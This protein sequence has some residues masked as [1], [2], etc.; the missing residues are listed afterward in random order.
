MAS[1]LARYLG[2]ETLDAR[3][4]FAPGAAEGLGQ[5]LLDA[6]LASLPYPKRDRERVLAEAAVAA[7]RPDFRLV[8]HRSDAMLGRLFE[9]TD[10]S[11]IAPATLDALDDIL[12]YARV[13]TLAQII[14]YTRF[15]MLTDADGRNRDVTQELV[16][17]RM[18]FPVLLLHG[19]RSGVFDW[20][21]SLESYEWL[22]R[23]SPNTQQL[24]MARAERD[25][26]KMHLGLNTSRQ[27]CVFEKFGH[28]DSMIGEKAATTVFPVVGEFLR[29]CNPALP[30]PTP[31]PGGERDVDSGDR[32]NGGDRVDEVLEPWVAELPW[33]GPIAGWLRPTNLSGMLDVSLLLHPSPAHASTRFVAIVPMQLK[34]GAW[35]QVDD[36]VLLW[37]DFSQQPFPVNDLVE[38]S[39][40]ARVPAAT[41]A[42]DEGPVDIGPLMRQRALRLRVAPSEVDGISTALLFLTVHNDLPRRT[43]GTWEQL[44]KLELIRAKRAV[45]QWLAA[46]PDDLTPG[47]LRLPAHVVDAIDT[48]DDTPPAERPRTPL[49]TFA[50]GS[51]QYPAGVLDHELA[52]AS[53]RRLA[54]RLDRDSTSGDAM[55]S[56]Q[57]L[58]LLGDQV[59]VDETAGLF[60]P[61]VAEFPFDEVYDRAFR[62]PAFR[63]VT[64]RLP[65]FMMLDD[66]EIVDNWEPPED[67]RDME[68]EHAKAL[69]KYISN[70]WVL[71]PV[72][73][74]QGQRSFTFHAA[75]GGWPLYVMDTRMTRTKR[76]PATFDSARMVSDDEMNA[77]LDWLGQQDPSVPKFVATPGV[78]LPFE[79][80]PDKPHWASDAWA[81]Y[82]ASRERLLGEIIS[83]RIRNVVFLAGDAHLSMVSTLTV[84][85]EDSDPIVLHSVVSSALYSPW[86]FANYHAWNYVPDGDVEVPVGDA[87]LQG[88]ITSCTRETNGF[89]VVQVRPEG[90]DHLL[91]VE[92]DPAEGSEPFR[93]ILPRAPA[94]GAGRS[95]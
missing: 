38:T 8:R 10:D 49:L 89:A 53:Y 29:S 79:V 6:V 71:N 41:P 2:V 76:T 15:A 94:G 90:N 50:F 27:L 13:E 43:G 62:P 60:N 46:P 95:D 80:E 20:R 39:S 24:W 34:G 31:R 84:P 47:L 42:A 4:S 83:R 77:L 65:T 92:F 14:H 70:Q 28:Q 18:P 58:L 9:L 48:F 54:R 22:R 68:T 36:R 91:V 16:T 56:P 59:Y 21:G 82:P 64:S 73:V 67:M 57:F 45:R 75:P 33:I 40:G 78:L 25:A 19:R 44:F 66:H 86:R 81:G 1:Y 37:K 23:S 3:P 72:H 85:V 35:Q 26:D 51:C 61:T 30:E 52:Q 32:G 87:T 11:P 88:H 5:T 63:A 93:F 55:Q 69:A 12:G 74:R 17:E 7:G